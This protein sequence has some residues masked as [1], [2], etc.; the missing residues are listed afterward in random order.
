MKK[1]KINIHL[2]YFEDNILQGENG[3]A[4]Y[5]LNE[6]NEQSPSS[7]LDAHIQVIYK[8]VTYTV[9][10]QFDRLES[11]F[12]GLRGIYDDIISIY[13][14]EIDFEDFVKQINKQIKNPPK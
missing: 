3:E 12:E 2:Y 9:T 10:R 5:Q 8:R 4:Y 6:V 7:Y 11:F 13:P 14:S 1:V